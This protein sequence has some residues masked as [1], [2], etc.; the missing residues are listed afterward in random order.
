MVS[1]GL[2]V[3]WRTVEILVGSLEGQKLIGLKEISGGRS[4]FHFTCI[5]GISLSSQ[6]LCCLMTVRAY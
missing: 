5:K 6:Y 4:H 2:G 3:S 1:G